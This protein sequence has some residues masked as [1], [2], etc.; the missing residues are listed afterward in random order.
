MQRGRATAASCGDARGGWCA[1][2]AERARALRATRPSHAPRRLQLCAR[3]WGP[4][5]GY[6]ALA[7]A[8]AGR[9][10]EVALESTGVRGLPATF[11]L[12][13]V[14]C[15][16]A[17]ALQWPALSPPVG[18]CVAAARS[19]SRLSRAGHAA[20]CGGR[21]R[22]LLDGSVANA[23]GRGAVGELCS[24]VGALTAIG[25]SCCSGGYQ[26]TTPSFGRRWPHVALA[27]STHGSQPPLTADLSGVER[28]AAG[29]ARARALMAPWGVFTSR[30]FR[31]RLRVDRR[32][33]D[34]RGL[35]ALGASPTGGGQPPRVVSII[36]ECNMGV[37]SP[38]TRRGP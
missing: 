10:S 35:E 12:E 13:R 2:R 32:V 23:G 36:Y 3:R 29:G 28:P 31:I 37:S 22:R 19:G 27:L 26:P 25:V 5:E 17:S 24:R 34:V 20:C 38:E 11:E 15:T 14:Q 21:S 9:A 4:S 7:G 8:G 33:C 30:R 1:A 6:G 16:G 18:R